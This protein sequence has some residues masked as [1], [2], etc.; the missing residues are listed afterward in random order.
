MESVIYLGKLKIFTVLISLVLVVF[1][2]KTG[3]IIFKLQVKR[4]KNTQ[5]ILKYRMNVNHKDTTQHNTLLTNNLS[6]WVI[7]GQQFWNV[8]SL[9]S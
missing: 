4:K 9:E 7:T 1:E 5:E 2:A 3:Q 8:S 6:S